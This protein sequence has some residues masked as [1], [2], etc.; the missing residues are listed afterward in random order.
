MR[1]KARLGRGFTLIELM[2]VIVIISL[3]AIFLVPMSL[4]ALC[5]ARAGTA[6]SLINQLSQAAKA[7]ELDFA[8]YPPGKGDGSKELITALSQKGP[9]KL[10][11]LELSP[12]LLTNGHV[13][14][15]VFGGEGGPPVDLI[16]YRNNIARA[17]GGNLA[18]APPKFNKSS[19]DL[20]CAGC[21]YTPKKPESAWSIRY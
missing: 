21:D 1:V 11:Y 9:K 8:V 5:S 17:G 12:E 6:A 16:Y 10:S 4:K 15:P 20:W 18:A 19:F 7:Y 13:M 3:L 2:V 14:N